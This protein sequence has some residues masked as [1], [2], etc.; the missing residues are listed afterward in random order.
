M[1]HD[2]YDIYYQDYGIDKMDFFYKKCLEHLQQV[3]DMPW[4]STWM[5]TQFHTF[6]GKCVVLSTDLEGAKL[7]EDGLNK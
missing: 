1:S 7:T 4:T 6:K 3:T 2:I 5:S